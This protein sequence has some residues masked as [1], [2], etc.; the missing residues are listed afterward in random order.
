M[1]WLSSIKMWQLP[2]FLWKLFFA[3]SG[4]TFVC[5]TRDWFW[6]H[7]SCFHVSIFDVQKFICLIISTHKLVKDFHGVFIAC[8][9]RLLREWTYVTCIQNGWCVFLMLL[10]IFSEFHACYFRKNRIFIFQNSF[11]F[12][13]RNSPKLV[14]RRFLC[15][16]NTKEECVTFYFISTHKISIVISLLGTYSILLTMFLVTWNVHY[17]NQWYNMK[18]VTH[19]L[20]C[21]SATVKSFGVTFIHIA[22][23][24]LSDS[25]LEL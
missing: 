11:P 14:L 16:T 1:G 21:L 9:N 6:W 3:T 12:S 19:S 10:P 24:F 23:C 17:N 15:Q 13:F 2:G 5:V 22:V 8:L 20:K 25:L 18:D 4:L 7:C